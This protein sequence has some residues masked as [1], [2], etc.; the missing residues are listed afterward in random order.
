MGC[1]YA[2]VQRPPTDA[3]VQGGTDSRGGSRRTTGRLGDGRMAHHGLHGTKTRLM[4]V[5]TSLLHSSSKRANVK[6]I[7]RIRN[8]SVNAWF[9]KPTSVTRHSVCDLNRRL[10]CRVE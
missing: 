6:L 1:G 7:E 4:V 3:T 5:E 2:L 10:L 9:R 8:L